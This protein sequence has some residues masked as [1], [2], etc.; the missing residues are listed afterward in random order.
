MLHQSVVNQ[1]HIFYF[2]G[3]FFILFFIR[4]LDNNEKNSNTM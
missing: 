3:N 4:L 1:G 2:K